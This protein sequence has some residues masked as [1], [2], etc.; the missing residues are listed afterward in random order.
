MKN[1]TLKPR[2]RRQRELGKKVGEVVVFGITSVA[3]AV[4]VWA[5]LVITLI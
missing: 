2:E 5:F 4:A 1:Y 3:G